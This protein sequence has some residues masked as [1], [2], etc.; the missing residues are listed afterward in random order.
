VTDA[1]AAAD[2]PVF[3]GGCPRSGTT[4]V[5]SMLNSHPELAVPHETLFLVDGFRRRRRWGDMAE[6]A[7]RRRLASWV[8]RR[9]KARVK[10]LHKDTDELI[11]RMVAAPPTLGSV[12]S[13]GFQL[14]AERNGKSRW[15]DK[16]PSFIQN[17]DA[18][19]AMFPNAQYINVVRDPRA[20][21]ASIKRVG[22]GRP[23]WYKDGLA[24]GIDLWDR[25]QQAAA[26]WER[27]LGPD[28]FLE[29]QY[30]Q[31][32]AD[33]VEVLGRVA[34]F[35]ELDPAGVDAMVSFHE[36]ADIRAPEMHP[37]V[38]QPV[39]TESVRKWEQE[40]AAEEIA[41]VE[42]VLAGPMR[43]Y[44]Y[45]TVSQAVSIPGDL[46]RRLRRRRNFSRKRMLRRRAAEIYRRVTYRHPVAARP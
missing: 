41:L 32:V 34:R 28:Q 40:L 1:R 2:R 25:A 7:N 46:H 6:E 42:K 18:L 43:R 5:R 44:G 45:E 4:M 33:P 9:K 15:G 37:L 17:L 35:L 10:R 13:A 16:R 24:A 21:V 27:R 8:V 3:V 38:A 31:L 19:F 23:G 30:E 11:E 39:T 29:I 26:K 20:A 36:Q 22:E 14:Y 12:L